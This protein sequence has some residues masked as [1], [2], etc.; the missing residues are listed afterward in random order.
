MRQFQYRICHLTSVHPRNDT[1]IFWNECVSLATFGYDTL[2][3]VADGKGNQKIH[4]VLI[5]DS[6]KPPRNR[7]LRILFTPLKI[8]KISL[9]SDAQIYHLH[10]PELI[11]IG[12]LLKIFR[13]KVIYDIHEDVSVQIIGK[14]WIPRWLRRYIGFLFSKF[15][16]F[17]AKYFNAIITAT[18]PIRQKF[19]NI[20]PLV[21]D[22]KNY[23]A[24]L[25]NPQDISWKEK[26]NAICYIG[27]LGKSRMTTELVQ[28]MKNI[29]GKLILAGLFRNPSDEQA[30]K[31]SIGWQNVEYHGF[32]DREQVYGILRRSKIGIVVLHPVLCNQEA[33]PV[34]MFEYMSAGIPVIA[35]NFPVL[36]EIIEDNHVGITV[37][38]LNWESI[39]HTINHLLQ[40]NSLAE[41]LGKNGFQAV[42]HKYNWSTQEKKL[43]ALY[44]R[45]SKD[46]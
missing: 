26:E 2:L 36:K 4:E 18:S 30:A 31:A 28:S 40:N 9:N 11:P 13:K 10:D 39:T 1:R 38:P 23:P 21:V 46:K 16:G 41:Q 15:E 27:V 25:C 29:D 32:A 5:I 14:F 7:I 37:N 33:L 12:L 3:I 44:D 17:S 43:L 42:L 35:S 45:L 20:N 24:S 22:I 8:I 19:I 34:K 6:G